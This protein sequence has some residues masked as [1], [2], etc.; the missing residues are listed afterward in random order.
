MKDAYSFD[1]DLAS[2][3]LSYQ[4][5]FAAYQ[6]IFGRLELR[7]RAVA[8]DTGA[9]GGEISQEFHVLADTG[10]DALA[11]CPSS[12]YAANIEL[13]EA[14]A[15]AGER[16]GAKSAMACVPTPDRTT[17]AEVAEYLGL[18]LAST[19]KSLVLATERV[20]EE[21]GQSGVD[22]WLL[23][24]R[25]DHELNEVKA[26][27]L[28]GLKAGFRFAT[29]AEIESHFGCRPGFLGPIG[30]KAPVRVIA[31]RTVA[32]MSDW[33]CGANQLDHHLTGVNW[34]RDLPEP[35]LVA[36]L[37]NVVEGDPSPDGQGVIA[38][39]RGIEVGHVF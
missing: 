29:A 5:M 22:I 24:L 9:I 28:E 26:G 2:A 25:G 21:A 10:E 23:L 18:P 34:G 33:V 16:E 8:A 7:F 6:R 11:F 15:P 36:D 35:D 17:C 31:D 1:R 30:L 13:A 38:I 32:Q 37:R 39:Q 12:D 14:V 20:S 3:T 4:A 19:V 27:K